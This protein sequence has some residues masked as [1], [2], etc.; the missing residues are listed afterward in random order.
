MQSITMK[1]NIDDGGN[2]NEQ[3]LFKSLRAD[4]ARFST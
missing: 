2:N 3:L 4:I 1:S